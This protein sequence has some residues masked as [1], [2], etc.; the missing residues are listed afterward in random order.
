MYRVVQSGTPKGVG[1]PP[2]FTLYCRTILISITHI[3]FTLLLTFFCTPFLH[4]WGRF[5]NPFIF[6]KNEEKMYRGKNC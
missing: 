1:K 4:F 3:T 6:I 2:P 5:A